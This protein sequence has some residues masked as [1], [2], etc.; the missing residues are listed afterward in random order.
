LASA[1]AAFDRNSG[2]AVVSGPVILFAA[3]RGFVSSYEMRHSYL[4]RTDIENSC[5]TANWL[6]SRKI[7]DELNGFDLSLKT[8]GDV[9][10]PRRVKAAGYDLVWADTMVVEH[11]TRT[12]LEDLIRKQS[13]TLGGAWN[14][15]SRSLRALRVLK[16]ALRRGLRRY[17]A[18]LQDPD[19]GSEVVS[20][21]L[22]I[23]RAVTAAE[24]REMIRL[25]FGGKPER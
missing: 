9:E 22:K 11:P 24:L 1:V 23:Q 19:I 13:R 21:L 3:D 8:G 2:V 18:I 20:G 10:F 16:H 7:Y 4:G 6:M 5:I 25:A 17:R 12:L 15:S 14:R